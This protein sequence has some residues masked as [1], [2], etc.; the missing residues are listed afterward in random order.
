MHETHATEQYFFAPPTLDEMA[1]LVERYERPALLCCPMLG[2]HLWERFQSPRFTPARKPWSTTI[3]DIDQRFAN[4]P[5]FAIWDIH[6]PVRLPVRP[7]I[8]VCDPPFYTIGLDRLFRAFGTLANGNPDIPI[9][10][11]Y[12]ERHAAKILGT[13]APFGLTKTDYYPKYVTVS[14]SV[15]IVAFSNLPREAW[16]RSGA[17]T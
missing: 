11:T 15:G 8:I 3:L 7:D 13:M 9:L 1:E 16:P 14:P 4:V 12:P 5:G 2:R 17:E 6:R 10:V